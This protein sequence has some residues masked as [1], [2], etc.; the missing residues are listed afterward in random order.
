MAWT[1]EVEAMGVAIDDGRPAAPNCC[2]GLPHLTQTQVQVLMQIADRKSSK[3]AA[4]ALGNSPHTVD[5]HV[6]D[7]LRMTGAG[8]R[9]E[10]VRMAIEQKI[11]DMSTG[12]AARTRKRCLQPRA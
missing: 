9:G 7:M 1:P 12:T 2:C 10:L 3:Q 8:D 11:V 5:S 6:K 4:A